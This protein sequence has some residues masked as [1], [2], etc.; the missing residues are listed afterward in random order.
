MPCAGLPTS[1]CAQRVWVLPDRVA[2]GVAGMGA[3]LSGAGVGAGLALT[4]AASSLA[5]GVT[6][7]Q[8]GVLVLLLSV[9]I[10][11]RWCGRAA[12]FAAILTGAAFSLVMFAASRAPASGADAAA[13]VLLAVI[14]SGIAA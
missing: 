6:L 12:G 7:S 8:G 11:S 10:A 5:T 9:L 4:A 14:G 13:L 2:Y 1:P 3:Y